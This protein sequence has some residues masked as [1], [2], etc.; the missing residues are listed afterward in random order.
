MADH[1]HLF[2]VVTSPDQVHWWLLENHPRQ[3]GA[4]SDC[5]HLF[6]TMLLLVVV[7]EQHQD[8]HQLAAEIVHQL[9]V[10]ALR[11][12]AYPLVLGPKGEPAESRVY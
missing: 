4:D 6:V 8:R 7:E 10:L 1:H 11:P 12:S 3:P 5:F 9:L 2:E